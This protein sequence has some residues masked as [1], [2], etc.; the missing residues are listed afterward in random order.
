MHRFACGALGN[1]ESI[2]NPTS[3]K[4]G[5]ISG[6]V[7]SADCSRTLTNDSDFAAILVDSCDSCVVGRNRVG[8][9]KLVGVVQ[10]GEGIRLFAEVDLALVAAPGNPC[11]LLDNVDF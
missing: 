8:N 3:G 7:S 9:L 6:G 10:C 2:L 11:G 5:I 1:G 4:F